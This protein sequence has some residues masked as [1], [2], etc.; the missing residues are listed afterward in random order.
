[1]MAWPAPEEYD[2]GTDLEQVAGD[3]LALER[4]GT[5]GEDDRDTAHRRFIHNLHNQETT[6][7]VIIVARLSIL[8]S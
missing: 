3:K 2:Y 6:N 5:V 4:V 8:P 7:L 1:M